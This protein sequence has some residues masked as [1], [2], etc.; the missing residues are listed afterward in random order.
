MRK[1]L[2]IRLE[3]SELRRIERLARREQ[4]TVAEWVRQTLRAARRNAI[5]R[6]LEVVRTAVQHSFP[7]AEVEE[8]LAQIGRGYADRHPR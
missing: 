6:K 3:E 7:T 2:G 5:R 8:M 4:I 1:R